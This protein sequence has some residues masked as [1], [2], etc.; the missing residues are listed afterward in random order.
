MAN[1]RKVIYEIRHPM[2]L[3]H[4]VANRML[5]QKIPVYS[6]YQ[7]SSTPHQKTPLKEPYFPYIPTSHQKRH[8]HAWYNRCGM[9]YVVLKSP[10]KEPHFPCIPIFHQK[11]HS[12]AWY[13]RCGMLAF[14]PSWIDST[15]VYVWVWVHGVCVYVCVVLGVDLGVDLGSVCICVSI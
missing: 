8:S 9:L 2:G 14:R 4:P 1:L 3:R 11:R 12:Q 13:N 5:H 10:L 6:F 7:N 15:Y